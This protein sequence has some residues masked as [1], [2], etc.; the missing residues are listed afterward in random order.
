[1][2]EAFRSGDGKTATKLLREIIGKNIEDDIAKVQCPVIVIDGI[3]GQLVPFIREKEI[4]GKFP[5]RV[6]TYEGE[7]TKTKEIRGILLA[8]TEAFGKQGHTVVNTSPEILA[9]LTDKMSSKLLE[10]SGVN[11]SDRLTS[12]I[13]SQ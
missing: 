10:L 2:L 13:E 3:N 9:V 8:V 6:L 12:N 4:A 1:M 5:S 11:E 7:I